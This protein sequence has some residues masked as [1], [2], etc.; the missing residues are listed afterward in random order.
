MLFFFFK[1]KTAYEIY[2]CDWSSDVCSSDL[3]FQKAFAAVKDQSLADREQAAWGKERA[4]MIKLLD[5]LQAA[6]DLKALRVAFAAFSDEIG[7]FAKSFGF[8]QV[9]NVY[10]LHCPMALGGQGAIWFQNDDETRNPYYGSAMLGCSD[11]VEL[12]SP[13]E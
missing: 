1:Q 10:Q 3:D 9:G 13:T 5:A 11:R 6:P 2:Q 7:V 12:V 8:G 4:K